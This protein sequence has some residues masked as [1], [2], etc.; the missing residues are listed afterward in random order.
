M[1]S[2]WLPDCVVTPLWGTVMSRRQFVAGM[3]T[4]ASHAVGMVCF[5]IY[6]AIP[7]CHVSMDNGTNQ[8]VYPAMSYKGSGENTFAI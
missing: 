6:I 1:M 2:L 4:S 5:S 7:W 8:G 3:W